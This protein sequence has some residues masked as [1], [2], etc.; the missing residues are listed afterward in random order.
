M[1]KKVNGIKIYPKYSVGSIISAAFCIISGAAIIVACVLLP[2]YTI[3][4]LSM[5]GI[6]F[7][8]LAIN[9]IGGTPEILNL[10]NNFHLITPDKFNLTFCY[11]KINACCEAAS[12]SSNFAV[13]WLQKDICKY[14]I[15]AIGFSNILVVLLGVFLFI[16]GVV[17]VILGT[18]PKHSKS[19]SILSFII[20]F[21][22]VIGIFALSFTT[23]YLI[24]DATINPLGDLVVEYS[25]WPYAAWGVMLVSFVGQCWI[26]TLL[27]KGKLYVAGARK[28]KKSKEINN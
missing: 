25:P 21:I 27:V 20:Y 5:S 23:K 13:F 26:K 11:E 9:E 24:E 19:L 28:I 17:R 16:K 14:I 1:A 8:F 10:S 4:G 6:D 7:S 15:I 3:G 22:F 12:S 2:V 18:Y